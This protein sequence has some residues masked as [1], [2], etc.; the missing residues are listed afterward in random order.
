MLF[1]A[2][3]INTF[4]QNKKVAL[5][6]K[7]TFVTAANIYIKFDSTSLIKVGNSFHLQRNHFLWL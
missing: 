6:G 5:K 4:G 7:V 2:F 3:S 1:F